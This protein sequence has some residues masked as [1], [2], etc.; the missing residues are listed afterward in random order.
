MTVLADSSASTGTMPQ[1]EPLLDDGAPY[2]AIGLV[3][4]DPLTDHIGLSPKPQ[5]GGILPALEGHTHWQ[6]G[7]GEHASPARRILGSVVLSA[8]SDQGNPVRIT[9]LVLDGSWQ[10]IVDR[11]VTRKANIEHIG[12]NVQVFPVSD[13]R[14]HISIVNNN[15]LSYVSLDRL[16]ISCNHSSTLACL[17]AT[18]LDTAPWSNVKRI[19]DKVHR[20]VC[21]HASFSD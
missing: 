8:K 5:L 14:E 4:L 1:P 9:H 18:T 17:S 3:E 2:S 11:N 21:G 20:H 15:F 19:V 7:T 12:R 10:W 6:H 16:T 13:E